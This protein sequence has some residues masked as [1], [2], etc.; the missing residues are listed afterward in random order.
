[1]TII[2]TPECGEPGC[3]NP[4]DMACGD[5]GR[6]VCSV[7]RFDHLAGRCIKTP[8]ILCP[9]CLKYEC[10]CARC[11][12]PGCKDG[13]FIACDCGK[14]VCYAHFKNLHKHGDGMEAWER[15]LQRSIQM[16]TQPEK[17]GGYR[18]SAKTGEI[19]Q[20]MQYH[21]FFPN[22]VRKSSSKIAHVEFE[23]YEQMQAFIEKNAQVWHSEGIVP[24]Y[25][26]GTCQR[27][28]VQQT[29]TYNVRL[30]DGQ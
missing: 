12:E 26:N 6:N 24:Y 5:C 17:I 15:D 2:G 11:E 10:T 19:K 22:D 28:Q 21:L 1:M 14:R 27:L 13:V 30:S 25:V 29:V 23:T 4:T 8:A 18:D 9:S 7:H 16:E 3:D 20:P